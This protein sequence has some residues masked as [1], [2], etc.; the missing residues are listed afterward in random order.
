MGK[1][2]F[3]QRLGT[4]SQAPNWILNDGKIV[5][6]EPYIREMRIWAHHFAHIE[7]LAPLENDDPYV[8]VAEYG[9][10]NVSFKFVHYSHSVKW[11]G[12]IL[13]F[14]QLPAVWLTLCSF[15]IRH[16][17]L[18]IRSPS[19]LGLYAHMIALILRKKSITKYAGL[20]APFVG[21]RQPS[22]IERW[23]IARVLR[24]PHFALV[25]GNIE[26]KHLISFIPASIS[27]TEIDDLKRL[28][29]AGARTANG[30][31]KFYSI[32]K[33]IPV[34]N[35]DLVIKALGM[36]KRDRPDFEWTYH[37][38]GDGRERE[39][40][41][42][43]AADWEIEPNIIFEGK[44]GFEEAMSQLARADFLIMPGT[45][46]GWPKVIIESWA[47]GAVPVV[48]DAGLSSAIIKD[49]I[50]GYL[51]K[52]DPIGL[53]VKLMQITRN[54]SQNEF[55]RGNGW[56]KVHDFSIEK[57]SDGIV[58]ICQEKL[59]LTPNPLP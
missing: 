21:E 16:D 20:F 19:H 48:A 9:F 2:R 56:D 38:I 41:E 59:C 27:N 49:G 57:F 10:E 31:A 14:V 34:K 51:F 22:K 13:R 35:Y 39:K 30:I 40:L 17:V 5:S 7:I 32:G 18:L 1:P 26:R 12:P 8:N 6:F 33:L 37:L 29:Q 11:Y 28:R 54:N 25:Y 3:N 58:Q 42:Q 46:E 55:I 53:K 44:L 23:F 15:I 50:N 36:L 4:I 47:V 45:M 52:P 43:L 24:P